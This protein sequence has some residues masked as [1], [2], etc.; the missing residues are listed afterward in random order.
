[1]QGDVEELTVTDSVPDFCGSPLGAMEIS[2][3]WPKNREGLTDLDEL[4]ST[5][6]GNLRAYAQLF[7]EVPLVQYAR[8]RR[9]SAKIWNFFPGKWAKVQLPNFHHIR[10]LGVPVQRIRHFDPD[11]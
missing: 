3:F 11:P 10:P 9:I 7:I 2:F 4:W 6:G 5:Y 8:N 1:M